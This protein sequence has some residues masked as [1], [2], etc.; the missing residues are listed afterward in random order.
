MRIDSAGWA[1]GFA[2]C[3]VDWLLTRQ[4]RRI[5]LGL[6][7]FLAAG[8]LGALVACGSMLDRDRLAERYLKLADAEVAQWENAWAP[9]NDAAP[10]PAD[11]AAEK[12][13]AGA[14]A[15]L[16]TDPSGDT[17][18]ANEPAAIPRFAEVLFR[19]VQQLQSDDQRSVFF[20]AMT[21]AQRGSLP[22]AL[23]LL[24]R[25]APDDRE[26]YAPAHAWLAEHY[27]K[28]PIS[29][30]NLKTIQHHARAAA[31]WSRTPPALL[32]SISQLF[33]RTGD[34]DAAVESLSRAADRDPKFHLHLAGL[35]AR[36]EKWKLLYKE[37]LSKADAHLTEVLE[38]NPHDVDARLQLI[39]AQ[40]LKKDF[41]AAERIVLEGRKLS[42]DPRL[43]HAQS[44]IYR[45]QFS[46][47]ASLVNSTWS[48]NVELLNK[49]FHVDPTN[50]KVFEE[51]AQMARI[52]GQVSDRELEAELNKL[53][54]EGKATS[55]THLWIAEHHL[56]KG[57][58][59][60]AIPH[61]E[62]ALQRSPNATHCLNNLAYCVATLYPDRREE[63]LQYIDRAISLY[64][65]QAAYHD[66]RGT[67][68][69]GL[70][71]PKEAIA[72]FERAVEL[73]H[74]A[75]Q[76]PKATYHQRLA[77][78]YESI[79]QKELAA[80]HQRIAARLL[81]ESEPSQSSG[82]VKSAAEQADSSDTASSNDAAAAPNAASN[83]ESD[84]SSQ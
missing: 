67:I 59:E 37:S 62:Q 33:W 45:L 12:A 79:G 4:W 26:G 74:Q 46:T 39:S 83:A 11:A 21:L 32:A 70:G 73:L 43:R 18:A 24:G 68:L 55:I 50:I 1:V 3:F 17:V 84:S 52:T 48:G 9:A 51:V 16:D 8:I 41:A 25:I 44:E 69:V 82:P 47:T 75:G 72:S 23:A 53:L 71:R 14:V 29:A 57:E 15:A 78:A 60:P 61:L 80:E 7:P 77:A 63:A 6:L 35:A 36:G 30:E 22:Q 10:E 76:P 56:V 19:R 42:D 38:R 40:L 65:G 58:L 81:K 20:V 27:L 64:P 28:Q 2:G 34:P 13:E 66:T 5:G 31:R 49:A 54:A